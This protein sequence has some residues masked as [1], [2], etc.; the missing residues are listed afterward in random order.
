MIDY[1]WFIS[2]YKIR[3]SKIL[4]SCA[5]TKEETI[6]VYHYELYFVLGDFNLNDGI[7]LIK[8]VYEV[9]RNDGVIK[10]SETLIRSLNGK[11]N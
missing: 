8:K 6:E 2:K 7:S 1:L 3:G 11:L 4:S 9:D 10:V 5:E